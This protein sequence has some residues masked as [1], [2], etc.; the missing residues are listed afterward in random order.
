MTGNLVQ[1]KEAAVKEPELTFK[2]NKPLGQSTKLLWNMSFFTASSIISNWGHVSFDGHPKSKNPYFP[3]PSSTP[4]SDALKF[5]FCAPFPPN[6]TSTWSWK[7]SSHN[8]HTSSPSL[9]F[10]LGFAL[11]DR[12]GAWC[13]RHD[14]RSSGRRSS[15]S[16]LT[17]ST[18]FNVVKCLVLREV[19][20]GIKI[21]TALTYLYT[22]LRLLL[23]RCHSK[24]AVL[25]ILI[26]IRLSLAFAVGSAIYTLRGRRILELSCNSG[27]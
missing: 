20:R 14:T 16:S 15:R 6:L 27:E 3:K 2:V 5:F 25:I 17:A 13:S 1:G 23:R 7:E 19:S 18:R 10:A 24:Y 21:I 8:K 22:I 11:R 12:C 26:I 4:Y 9:L